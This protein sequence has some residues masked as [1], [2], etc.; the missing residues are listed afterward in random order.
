LPQAYSSAR[1]QCIDLEYTGED[2][3]GQCSP[4]FLCCDGS[5]GAR[6]CF[7]V[8]CGAS[9]A[10]GKVDGN[11]E[12]VQSRI[13]GAP[14]P[15][16]LLP[17]RCVLVR[18]MCDS[19][20]LLVLDAS[21]RTGLQLLLSVVRLHAPDGDR[22]AQQPDDVRNLHQVLCGRTRTQRQGCQ[23]L[24]REHQQEGRRGVR[25]PPVGVRAARSF[26]PALSPLPPF[27]TVLPMSFKSSLLGSDSEIVCSRSSY[28]KEPSLLSTV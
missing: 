28:S 20:E 23:P 9:G 24:W 21:N 14:T 26:Q 6:V 5:S 8:N 15:Q 11:I 13:R 16:R 2:T 3:P 27:R 18:H 7:C 1:S 25:R 19:L 17:F 22:T 12:Q 4:T 10:C